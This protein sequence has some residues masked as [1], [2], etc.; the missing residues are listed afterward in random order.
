MTDALRYHVCTF[1]PQSAWCAF[2]T[3]IPKNLVSEYTSFGSVASAWW[4]ANSAEAVSSAE[5]CPDNWFKAM[6]DTPDGAYFLNETIAWA[7]CYAAADD[8]SEI[9]ATTAPTTAPTTT[10]APPSE[11]AESSP[12]A[13]STTTTTTKQS[14]KAVHADGF[15]MWVVIAAAVAYAVWQA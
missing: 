4:A 7:G 5:L 9:V 13:T 11:V 8:V 6:V 3:A 1:P 14:N 10:P 12:K 15:D 2:P